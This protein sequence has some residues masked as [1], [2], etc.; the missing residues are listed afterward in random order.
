[1]RE[2]KREARS[3]LIEQHLQSV[4]HRVS[5]NPAQ[6]AKAFPDLCLIDRQDLGDIHN[7]CLGKTGLALLQEHVTG[8]F[9]PARFKVIKQTTVV[10]IA[11]RL[12]TSF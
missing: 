6:R 10:A 9:C 5:R 8:R 7:A 3:Q 1:M 11:L 4:P 2:G 12:K